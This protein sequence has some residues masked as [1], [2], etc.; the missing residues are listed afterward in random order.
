MIT[1][2]PS[3]R[4]LTRARSLTVIGDIATFIVVLAIFFIL[5][6]TTSP[7]NSLASTAVA[8]CA[9]T[10]RKF[11]SRPVVNIRIVFGYKDARPARFVGDRHERLAFVQRI[12]EPCP[13]SPPSPPLPSSATSSADSLSSSGSSSGQACGFTRSPENADL[14]FTTIRGPDGKQVKVQ[15]WVANSSVGS[16]DEANRADPFQIWQSGYARNAFFSGLQG[17]AEGVFY[18]GHSRFGGGPDFEPPRLTPA[19]AVNEPYYKTRRPG[20]T[21]TLDIFENHL[22]SKNKS[23]RLKVL[24]L[25]SCASSKHFL[26]EIR[27]YS[28]TKLISSQNLIYHAE[29]LESSLAALSG[30]LEM[31]CQGEFNNLLAKSAPGQGLRLQ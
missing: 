17:D 29:A 15:L 20:L 5:A 26:E 13:P 6:L 23:E 25:F 16:D 24:G 30:L 1:M 14:F 8:D 7:T 18:N 27:Q 4:K 9:K 31:R 12:L 3:E 21:K 11:Y 19:G 28:D 10:Y 22:F 2:E